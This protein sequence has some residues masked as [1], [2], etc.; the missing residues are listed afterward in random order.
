MFKDLAKYNQILVTG[1]QRSGTTI[2]AKVIVADT[3]HKYIDEYDYKTSEVGFLRLLP[4][5]NNV[6]IQCPAM[7]HCLPEIADK[8]TL[9]V[10]MMRN[11]DDIVASEERIHWWSSGAY[12]ELKRLG[13]E[14]PE[15]RRFR[16]QGSRVSEVKY[17]RWEKIKNKI[18]HFLEL[19]YE[20]LSKHPLWIPKE[21][22]INFDKKQT[23]L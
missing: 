15:A 19:E 14:G 13:I 16:R 23:E 18:P 10:M 11:T 3:G 4:R 17:Q 12:R 2:A 5:N 7:F 9:V 6:V 21:K 20:S 22:R 8:N 1:P